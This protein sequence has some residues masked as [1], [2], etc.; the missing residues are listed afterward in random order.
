MDKW[1]EINGI[2]EIDSPSLVLYK[3]H[4]EHN[5][6]HILE[7]VNNQPDKL[8]LHV[9]TNKMPNVIAKCL[10]LGIKNFKA[11]T[12]SEAEM[13]ARTGA[14]SVLIAHQLVGPKIE[15][16]FKLILTFP[17]TRFSTIVDNIESVNMLNGFAIK[18]DLQTDIYIDIN[19][20]MNRSGIE[21]GN[22]LYKLIDK[23]N[24]CSNLLFKG[25]HLYDGHFRD[26][27]FKVRKDK[28]ENAFLDVTSIYNTLKKSFPNLQMVCGGTPSFTSHLSEP[29]RI[30]SPGTCVFWDYGYS[31]KLIEQHFKF[32]VLIISRVISNPSKGI[33]TIDLGH[34]AVG[35]ENPIDKRVRFLNLKDYE[36]LSQSEEHGVLALD[37]DSQI[38]IGDVLYGVPYHI[39]PT[40]NL[41]DEVSVISE[42]E[43][44]DTWEITARRRKL[45]I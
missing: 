39:C 7:M 18:L 6:K 42:G 14:E 4:L 38:A 30:C 12:T 9:K 31:E 36:L 33:V 17:K 16:F 27:D 45:T 26:S 35:A 20:G 21:A 23:I 25:L 13:A 11:S 5:L 1:Y 44:T 2:Q 40:V 34:K 19:N 15:R 43:K 37:D 29:N 22:E 3:N 24:K 32:A 28:V 10:V 8:M 41:Y